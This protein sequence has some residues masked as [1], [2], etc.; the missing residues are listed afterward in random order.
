MCPRLSVSEIAAPAIGNPIAAVPLTEAGAG[1]T[2][3][4]SGKLV[5]PFAD[6]VI[7]V[8]PVD[9]PV[10][11]PVLLIVAKLVAL[12]AQAKVTPFIVFPLL[13]FAVAENC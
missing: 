10:A 12:L 7:C 13:S 6:A 11:S 2:V 3:N 9:A 5:I 8:V 4:V 1:V